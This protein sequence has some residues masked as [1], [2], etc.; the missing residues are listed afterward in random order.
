MA[1]IEISFDGDEQFDTVDFN[2]LP[3][4]LE[5]DHAFVW[6]DVDAGKPEE[7]T[8]L[9]EQFGLH[10]LAV[11]SALAEQQRA[12]ITL[13]DD[14]IYLEFY[15][16]RIAGD[17]V[18]A[19]DIGI[20]VGHKFIITV[21]RNDYPSLEPL[22]QRWRDEQQRVRDTN[23]KRAGQPLGGNGQ[24]HRKRP[25]SAM[26]LYAL[27]DDLVDQYFPVIERLGDQIEE[28]EEVVTAANSPAPQLDI[29]HMRTRLLRLRRLISPEQEVLN[30]LLRRDIPVIDEAIIPYFAEVYDHVLRIYDW[31]ESYRDQLSTIVDLQ[32][33]MQSNNLN[34]TVRTLTVWS[35]ILMSSTLIAGVYGMNFVHMPELAWLL[36]YPWALG[37]MVGVG[38]GLYALFRKWEWL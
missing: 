22:Q 8:G 28:L 25:S 20:F 3:D 11:E 36:G 31:M 15:G 38:G 37:L 9:Q 12:K 7:L 32:L 1:R 19:D 26:L 2:Q 18:L 16:L 5:R 17:D 35:I 14:M 10:Q 6:I 29:Q 24:T 30:S 27:L 23:G 21:R 13:Y 33:S 34:Q 4:F